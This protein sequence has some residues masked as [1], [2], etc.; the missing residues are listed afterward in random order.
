MWSCGSV[1]QIWRFLV[2]C[3][4][5]ERAVDAGVPAIPRD[6]IIVKCPLCGEKR[7]YRPAEVYKGWA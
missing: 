5:C 4:R 3:K 6:N 2:V 7:R 1:R